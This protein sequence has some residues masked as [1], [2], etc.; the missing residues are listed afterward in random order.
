MTPDLKL[1]Q[2]TFDDQ[3]DYVEAAT[4]S[5]AI[6]TWHACMKGENGDDWHG[7]EEPESCAL[8]HRSAVI[9]AAT[10]PA[11]D[12][13]ALEA[14]IRVGGRLA[15]L[16]HNLKQRDSIDLATRGML[17]DEQER[18]DVELRALRAVRAAMKTTEAARA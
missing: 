11:P 2:I 9:R 1:F 10:P 3:H 5:A 15:N 7:D 4:M 14:L 13:V 6:A 12:A 16:A 18:W 8:V 17:A